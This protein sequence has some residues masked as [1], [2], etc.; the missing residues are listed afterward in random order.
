MWRPLEHAGWVVFEDIVLYVHCVRAAAAARG[1]ALRQ[2]AVEDLK[3]TIEARVERRTAQLQQS[4]AQLEIVNAELRAASAR[5]EESSRSK[6]AFLA[7]VSHEVRTPMNGIIGVTELLR[8]TGLSP[9]QGEYVEIIERSGHSLLGIINDIL[10]FSKLEA[11][12]LE[13]ES[14]DFDLLE[15]IDH[16]LTVL[17]HKA[18][19]KH[20]AFG[21]VVAPDVPAARRRRCRA[22]EPGPHQPARQRG[23][24]HRPG[25]RRAAG[26][27]DRSRRPRPAL[28]GAGHRDGHRAVG[29]RAAV[30]AIHP[31]GRLDDPA[32]RRD[33]PGPR[34]QPQPRRGARA[35]P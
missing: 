23:E 15:Q 1:M 34:H 25:P 31:G 32:L 28:R 30:P 5:A 13:I 17:G 20:L 4:R 12:K 3:A 33:R 9:D 11:G 14:L 2:V 10:D 26:D 19:A 21:A 6:S 29:A 27:A 35:A 18:E 7:T 16:V 22:A 24:V 8:D